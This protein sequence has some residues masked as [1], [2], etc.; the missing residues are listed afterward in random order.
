MQQINIFYEAEQ[1]YIDRCRRKAVELLRRRESITIED[2]AYECPRP[3]GVSKKVFAKVFRN[4]VFVPIGYTRATGTLA[5]G[6][7]L[8]KWALNDGYYEI[9]D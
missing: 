7:V 1:K 5:N 8:R 6:H 2:V 4:D 3:Q 9:N